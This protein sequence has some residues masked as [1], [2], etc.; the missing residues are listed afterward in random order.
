L[1]DTTP[2]MRRDIHKALI[3]LSLLAIGACPQSPEFVTTDVDTSTG[4]ASTGDIGV[5]TSTTGAEV[6]ATTEASSTTGEAPPISCG[7]PAAECIS[8]KRE[9]CEDLLDICIAAGIGPGGTGTD[10]CAIVSS[11]CPAVPPCQ[12]CYL[13]ASTCKQLGNGEDYCNFI[14][15][16]CLC[17]AADHD[18]NIDA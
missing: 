2:T 8:I 7:E 18:L 10:Y 13:I 1:C 9:W 14:M 12:A 3:C 5:T 4:D 17:R 11:G 6:T 16:D 15:A